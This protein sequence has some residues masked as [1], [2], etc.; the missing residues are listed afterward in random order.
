[1]TRLARTTLL[2]VCLYT[3]LFVQITEAQNSHWRLAGAMTTPRASACS[4]LLSDGRILIAGGEGPRGDL[5]SAE[6]LGTDGTFSAAPDMLS[7]RSRAYLC[8]S[9]GRPRRLPAECR[10][11]RF[12][13]TKSREILRSN[14]QRSGMP[15]AR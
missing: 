6:F 10:R 14:C 8:D 15:R 3:P 11:R 2:S 12:G 1:M 9:P 7:A 13:S 5:A 4:A